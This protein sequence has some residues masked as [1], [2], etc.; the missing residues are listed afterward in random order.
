VRERLGYLLYATGWAVV[1]RL[2]ERAAYAGFA[3]VADA[4]W[5]VRPG[6]VRRLERNL[7]RVVGPGAPRS[8]PRAL[9]RAAMR[10]YMRYW[11]EVF[12]LPDWDRDRTVST[13]R[14][15]HEERLREPL[16]AGRGVVAPL[17]HMGNWDH[18][19]AWA[20]RTGA[21]VTT[22]AERVRPERLYE[23]FL[24]YRRAIGIEIVPLTGGPAPP[25]DLLVARAGA[26]RLVP[27]LADRDLRRGGGVRVSFFG[28]AA[29]FPPGPAM[30]AVRTG[31]VLL[32][33]T[34]HV[35]RT[36]LV[37]TFHPPV[38]PPASGSVREQVTAMTQQ[39]AATF[40]RAI[41]EHPADWHMLQPVW[42][43]DL[44]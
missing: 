37:L 4:V 16:A 17:P 44:S 5:R 15:V 20:A 8:V 33:V 34:L 26:G 12:R 10:S 35:E 6:A 39:V 32:P 25:M 11:C 14:T 41:R 29:R 27:L 3:L 19:G 13:V 22:V 2:P 30:L 38:E 1:R 18:A 43:A 31:A 7:R 24:A 9:A 36:D 42:E 40:E 28:E 21:P 23:R